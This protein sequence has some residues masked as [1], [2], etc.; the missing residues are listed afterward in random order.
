MLTILW[1]EYELEVCTEV[2]CIFLVLFSLHKS[3]R[4][5]TTFIYSLGISF[6]LPTGYLMSEF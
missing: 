3:Y 4:T 1:L 6:I 2:S 5:S